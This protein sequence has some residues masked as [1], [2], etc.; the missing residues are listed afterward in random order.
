YAPLVVGENQQNFVAAPGQQD[1]YE[2]ALKV[3]DLDLPDGVSAK[4]S[5]ARVK[6]LDEMEE[7]FLASRSGLSSLSH[8]SAYQRAVTLMRSAATKA[9]NLDDE[10]KEL[11]DKYGRNLF[12]QGCLLARRLVERGVPF[13][14]VTLS[15]V[16]GAQALGW[17]THV[18]N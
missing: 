14:E 12:G 16:Q 1:G 2:R 4:R 17:D 18:N 13:V 7:D 10:P 11:R 15:G 6:L 5:E 3:Q 9:F 8:R